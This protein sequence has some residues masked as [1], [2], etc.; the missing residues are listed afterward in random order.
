MIR[1]KNQYPLVVGGR[2][3][4]RQQKK[5]SATDKQDAAGPKEG[6]RG[7]GKKLEGEKSSLRKKSETS[8]QLR[9][10]RAVQE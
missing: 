7:V 1:T 2:L 9:C 8:R 3:G 6:Q 4:R 10:E 5:T